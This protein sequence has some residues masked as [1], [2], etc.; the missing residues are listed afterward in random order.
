[1][2]VRHHIHSKHSGRDG[3]LQIKDLCEQA[4]THNETFSLT[5]HGSIGGWVEA[6]KVAKEYDMKVILGCEFYVH[7]KRDELLSVVETINNT[8]DKDLLLQLRAIRDVL[9]YNEHICVLARTQIGLQNIIALNNKAY[10]NGFYR[11]PLISYTELFD[12]VEVDENGDDGLIIT[13]ACLGNKINRLLVNKDYTHAKQ[14]AKLFKDRFGKYYFLEVQ[15]NDIEEQ[16]VANKGLIELSKD[17]EIPLIF[18]LDS[19]YLHKDWSETHQDLL[20]L[21]TKKTRDDLDKKDQYLVILNAKGEEK[22]KKCKEGI[23]KELKWEDIQIGQ[24]I[25]NETVVEKFEKDR[26]WKFST[27]LVYYKSEANLKDDVKEYHPELLS[28]LDEAIKNNYLIDDMCEV[29]TMDSSIKLPVI[30]ED[31]KKELKKQIAAGLI[32]NN[33][34]KNPI[35]LDRIKHEL[36]VICDNS[37]EDYFLVLSD[38][39]QKAK[40]LGIPRGAGRGSAS[41]SLIGF[42]LDIHS[43]DPMREDLFGLMPF[44]RFLDDSRSKKKIFISDKNETIELLEGMKVLVVRDNKDTII[45]AEELKVGDNFKEIYVEI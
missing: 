1:M 28:V 39:M 26:A 11:K 14:V 24:K 34:G 27:N 16:R 25:G 41:S 44:G 45:L 40:E 15:A 33:I 32:R 22:N 12:E 18:G 31:S 20:L 38:I 2:F 6:L 43:I 30:F 35:Y 3:L 37:F 29:L 9:D 36:K 10:V 5:D 42:L 23:Y 21:Q 19:H 4:K 13:S 8:T 17:L 7:D